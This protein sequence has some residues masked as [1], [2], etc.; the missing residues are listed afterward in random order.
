VLA[1]GGIADGRGVAA[2]LVLGAVGALVGTRFQASH[3]A[4]VSPEVSK[5]I[6]NARGSDTE[7]NR[8]LD[9]AR[10]AGWPERYTARTLGNDFLDEWRGREDELS[11]DTATLQAYRESGATPVWASQAVDLI[12]E[13]DSATLLVERMATAAE[14]ALTSAYMASTAAN[15][16]SRIP[17]GQD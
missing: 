9:I 17:G 11:A 5:A 2:A 8:I 14:R 7:R 10:G 12:T 4:L 3:E 15:P 13:V 1:A 6:V 16:G